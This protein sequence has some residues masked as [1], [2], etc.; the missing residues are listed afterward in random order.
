MIFTSTYILSLGV[1][2]QG[3]GVPWGKVARAGGKGA[4]VVGGPMLV[5]YG[6]GKRVDASIPEDTAP[7][8]R[9]RAKV[10]AGAAAGMATGAIIG[11]VIPGIGT[12]IGAGVGALC[13]AVGAWLS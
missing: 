1:T 5:G 6:G 3:Q 4:A 13:G 8:T 7:S 12:G 2:F 10:V 9:T 11:S